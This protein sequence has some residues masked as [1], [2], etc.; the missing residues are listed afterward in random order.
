MKINELLKNPFVVAGGVGLL[1]FLYMKRE[2][3][4]RLKPKNCGCGKD[5]CET[6]GKKTETEEV[7]TDK[8]E[9]KDADFEALPQDFLEDVAKMDK[10]ELKTTIKLNQDLAK[11]KKLSR[12]ER[13]SIKLMME[14]LKQEYANR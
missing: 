6:Y 13:E 3:Q 5:P 8:E 14:Y 7:S 11:R 12:D 10:E 9:E 4:K 2:E 1:V